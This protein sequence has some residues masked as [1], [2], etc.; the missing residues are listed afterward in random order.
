MTKRCSKCKV[1]Y[2]KTEFHKNKRSSD[3]YQTVCKE[4]NKQNTRSRDLD[5]WRRQNLKRNFG[6]TPEQYDELLEKQNHCCALCEKHKDL[7]KRSL[8][9]DHNHKT[10]RIRGLLCLNCNYRLVGKHTDSEML[11]RM[12]DYID[13]GTEWY[14]PSNRPKKRRKKK[15]KSP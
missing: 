1:T 8:A 7:E 5:Y 12:A 14:V 11:R 3:G 2:P 10:G 9:V 6:L 13:Q 4:C 15:S